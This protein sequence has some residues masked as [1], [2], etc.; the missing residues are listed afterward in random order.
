MCGAADHLHIRG[1]SNSLPFC[2]IVA[3][4]I[5]MCAPHPA[6]MYRL[7]VKLL[8][9]CC[10][11]ILDSSAARGSCQEHCHGLSR[12]SC[13]RA[14]GFDCVQKGEESQGEPSLR[15]SALS[16]LLSGAAQEDIHLLEH[17]RYD[18]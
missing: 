10:H 11:V 3:Y 1:R 18:A 13:V 14:V 16:L 7:Y 12:C 5:R 4:P 8:Q 2:R 9:R 6:V 15:S 17:G